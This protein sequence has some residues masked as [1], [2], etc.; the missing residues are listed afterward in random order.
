MSYEYSHMH[1]Q[2]TEENTNRLLKENKDLP[3][4]YTILSKIEKENKLK[5]HIEPQFQYNYNIQTSKSN[6]E[7]SFPINIESNTNIDML[8]KKGI[9]QNHN[10]TNKYRKDNNDSEISSFN[11]KRQNDNSKNDIFGGFNKYLI[12]SN[13]ENPNKEHSN[14]KLIQEDNDE[15]KKELHRLMKVISVLEI[16]SNEKE[17]KIN[18]LLLKI[19]RIEKEKE[20]SNGNF[21]IK[22]ISELKNKLIQLENQLKD[23]QNKVFEAKIS[24]SKA[25]SSLQD[26][27]Q[28]SI[29]REGLKTVE[30]ERKLN[31]EI[32]QIIDEYE[33]KLAYKDEE[34]S[35]MKRKEETM[36]AVSIEKD[37]IHR[38]EYNN[39]IDKLEKEYK[40]NLNKI[41]EDSERERINKYKS[42][43][44]EIL[45]NKKEIERKYNEETKL[46]INL[47][48]NK[49]KYERELEEL[50]EKLIK[51]SDEIEKKI[52]LNE[53]LISQLNIYKQDNEEFKIKFTEYQIEISDLN[54]EIN[55]LKIKLNSYSEENSALNNEYKTCMNIQ[56]EYNSLYN[57]YL[58]IKEKNSNHENENIQLKNNLKSLEEVNKRLNKEVKSIKEKKNSQ[59][60]LVLNKVSSI[61]KEFSYMISLFKEE[62]KFIYKEQVKCIDQIVSRLNIYNI[63]KDNTLKLS[64]YKQKEQYERKLYKFNEYQRQYNEII[65][66]NNQLKEDN[67]LL[68]SK[69]ESISKEINDKVKLVE[70]FY[71]NKEHV[72]EV[73]NEIFQ[74]KTKY[75]SKIRHIN[76][77]IE[78]VILDYNQYRNINQLNKSHI[79]ELMNK[80]SIYEAKENTRL[81]NKNKEVDLKMII[82]STMKNY[83]LKGSSEVKMASKLDEEIREMLKD[84]NKNNK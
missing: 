79:K 31:L 45:I 26:E 33:Q 83:S 72:R 71:I 15:L 60:I 10:E 53:Q 43:L 57:E 3:N 39:K 22:S 16:E 7:T 48:Q 12:P 58:N 37:Y 65:L 41:I 42:E 69:I 34:I 78:S 73:Y 74:L 62:V 64:L 80:I 30:L 4:N 68:N 56:N 6:T 8:N 13:N 23:E 46:N 18:D 21:N 47:R 49:E 63:D 44:E 84:I 40:Y 82:N 61:K 77:V 20:L 36:K 81:L 14:Y 27:M 11:I 70:G 38:S 52:S 2:R 32:K 29:M 17:I 19:E 5:T 54:E 59:F 76:I 9:R 50:N 25:L 75:L 24:Y 55:Q 67:V 1:T 51:Q 35:F 66:M 28:S